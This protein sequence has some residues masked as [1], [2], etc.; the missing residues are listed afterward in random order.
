MRP[1]LHGLA[2]VAVLLGFAVSFVLLGQVIGTTSPW[3]VLLLMFYFLGLAKVAEPLF[4]LRMPA[5]LR[6]LRR[7]E[8]EGH[9][10]RR[11]GV[12]GFG[13]LLRRT[14]LRYLNSAVYLDRARRHPGQV[15]HR[16]ESAE[17]SHFWVAVLFM[18]YVV[19]AALGGMWSV[20]AW[21]LLAQVL[22]NVYPILHLRHVRGRLDRIIGRMDAAQTMKPFE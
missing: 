18:P 20:A 5:A 21:C 11:L 8:R 10:Y 12:V 1:W 3:L 19:F 17:A 14:P 15:R 7:W 13:R 6:P 9:V 16:A 4:V 2:L 22:V